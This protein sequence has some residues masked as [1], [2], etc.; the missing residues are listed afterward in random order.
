[1]EL[2]E[3]IAQKRREVEAAKAELDRVN[4]AQ[5]IKEQTVIFRAKHEDKLKDTEAKAKAVVESEAE[6]IAV[7]RQE[8]NY[9]SLR[10]ELQ[11][12]ENKASTLKEVCWNIRAQIKAFQE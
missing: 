4:L 9:R 12:L 1:M 7:I 6:S 8:G 11:D 3:L 2:D 5:K 10:I